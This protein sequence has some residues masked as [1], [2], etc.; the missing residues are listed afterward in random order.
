MLPATPARAS[1]IP[2]R[3]MTMKRNA[4]R[5]TEW[6][7]KDGKDGFHHR[8]WM[9]NQGLQNHLFDG[10][11]VIGICKTWSELTPCNAHFRVLAERV[12][13]LGHSRIAV[14]SGITDG[15]DRARMR[16]E[17]VRAALEAH[18]LDPAGLP[19]IETR[20]AFECGGEAFDRLMAIRPRPTAVMCGNDVLAVGALKRARERNLAVPADISITGFDDIEL[21]QII[22]PALTTIR[23]PHR[24]M[25]QR[26]AQELIA[27]VEDRSTGASVELDTS[28]QTRASLGPAAPD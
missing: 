6:F 20:Y 21:A 18:G 9:K 12:I 3:A 1:P 14:I 5:S 2:R 10:R 15:N 28:L 13:G 25:G 26:A 19:M 24:Q 16:L 17:G 27:I 11:P 7:G 4:R 22:D 23:V 8:S